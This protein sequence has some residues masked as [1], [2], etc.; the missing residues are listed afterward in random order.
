MVSNNG[1]KHRVIEKPP[2]A[3]VAESPAM[4]AGPIPSPSSACRCV[5]LVGRVAQRRADRRFP[6]ILLDE[7]ARLGKHRP[8]AD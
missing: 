5:V 4:I 3:Q 6:P 8:A 1:S 2:A 7:A